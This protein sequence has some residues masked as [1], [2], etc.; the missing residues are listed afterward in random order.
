M[1]SESKDSRVNVKIHH[2]KITM[3]TGSTRG[4]GRAIS[5]L[6]S[7]Q[8]SSMVIVVSDEKEADVA[9]HEIKPSGAWGGP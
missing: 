3:G 8:G 4:N 6:P 9:A 7:L 5:A 2:G 1:E